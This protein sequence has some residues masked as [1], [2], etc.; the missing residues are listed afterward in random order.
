LL[1]P[2][3]IGPGTYIKDKAEGVSPKKAKKELSFGT[4]DR[5]KMAQD[6]INFPGPGNYKDQNKWNK[7]SYN[8]KFLSNQVN[9]QTPF[10]HNHIV[11][12]KDDNFMQSTGFARDHETLPTGY[13]L[14]A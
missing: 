8:L 11:E 6:V 3:N 7:R 12:N 4:D 5:F 14:Q 1:A 10:A 13:T 9:K 2:I